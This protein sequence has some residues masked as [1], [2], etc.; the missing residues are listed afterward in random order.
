MELLRT[1]VRKAKFEL[2]QV[3]LQKQGAYDVYKVLVADS[4]AA[5]QLRKKPM[6]EWELW[7]AA[8]KAVISAQQGRISTLLA[9]VQDVRQESEARAKAIVA[10]VRT[11][12]QT[13][14]QHTFGTVVV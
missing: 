1:E 10:Q 5:K 8:G 11:H 3:P 14:E 12:A 9:N 7:E 6:P 4:D 13:H 2:S